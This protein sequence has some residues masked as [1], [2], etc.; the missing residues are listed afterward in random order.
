MHIPRKAASV[1][2]PAFLGG[3]PVG[4]KCVSD[5]YCNGTLSKH[6]AER[7]L[8]F[9]SN[10][11]PSFLFGMVSANFP[12]SLMVWELWLV[13]IAAAIF[14]AQ[15]F[16]APPSEYTK[17]PS[18][19]DSVPKSDAML[20]AIKAMASICGWVIVFRTLMSFLNSNFIFMLPQWLLVLASGFLEL[21]NGCC[22]LLKIPDVKL[23]FVLCGCMLSFGSICVLLQTNSVV[24]GLSLR[25]YVLGKLVQTV[26]SFVLCL[27]FLMR[28]GILIAGAGFVIFGIFVFGKNKSGNL[29]AFPV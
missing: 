11:G 13:H 6:E 15:V 25:Y 2:I 7:M 21:S 14:T 12:D 18:S 26:V 1:V 23:R 10:A 19:R 3:Y 17:I 27:V 22:E 5:L 16:P 24:N 4:A 8:A 29:N 20:S 9:S 28:Y